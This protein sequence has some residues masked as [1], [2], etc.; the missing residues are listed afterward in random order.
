MIINLVFSKSCKG[1]KFIF[2][3]LNRK[4]DEKMSQNAAQETQTLN[5]GKFSRRAPKIKGENAR[6]ITTELFQGSFDVTLSLIF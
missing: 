3:K 2:K 4:T 5:G 1:L 6:Q